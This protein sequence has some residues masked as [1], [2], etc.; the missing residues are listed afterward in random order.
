[1]TT[2]QVATR[3]VELCRRG[4]YE[5]AQKELYAPDA[6]SIEPE[7]TPDAVARGAA[8]LAAKAKTFAESFIVHG[9]SVSDPIVAGPFFACTMSLDATDR[10]SGQRLTMEEVCVYEVRDGLIVREQFFY[11]VQPY[12]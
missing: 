8:A 11:P 6:V 3:L 5:E 1:M 7:G 2:S 9:G 4:T 12:A 10:K